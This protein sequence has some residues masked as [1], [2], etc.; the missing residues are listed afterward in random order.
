MESPTGDRFACLSFTA[1]LLFGCQCD[2][3]PTIILTQ[4]F[5]HTISR[6]FCFSSSLEAMGPMK[7]MKARFMRSLAADLVVE[8]S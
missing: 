6:P 5:A 3:S 7:A 4:P 2:G 8:L 1:V